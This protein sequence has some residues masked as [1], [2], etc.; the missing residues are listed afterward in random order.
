MITKKDWDALPLKAKR[1]IL[2]AYYGDDFEEH[3]VSKQFLYEYRHNFD[4]DEHGKRLKQL[5][6]ML[7][8]VSS[9]EIYLKIPI[10]YDPKSNQATFLSRPETPKRGTKAPTTNASPVKR[11]EWYCDYIS[12]MDDDVAHAWC[13]ADSKESARSYFLS[14]YWDIKEIINIYRK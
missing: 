3:F 1:E 14:E 13:E 11:T 12:K 4:F 6:S 2:S 7:Y 8:R 5:L 9:G 10:T